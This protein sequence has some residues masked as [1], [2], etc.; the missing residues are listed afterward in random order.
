MIWKD[1]GG[2]ILWLNAWH[3]IIYNLGLKKHTP[4]RFG[5]WHL[6]S[7]YLIDHQSVVRDG[8]YVISWPNVV[9]QLISAIIQQHVVNTVIWKLIATIILTMD[10]VSAA[11]PYAWPH[12]G[13][14]Q[15]SNT[16]LIIVDVQVDHPFPPSPGP[17][18]HSSPV[19]A[20]WSPQYYSTQSASRAEK[21]TCT[22]LRQWSYF[23]AQNMSIHYS[24]TDSGWLY[25]NMASNEQ[26]N[27]CL[28]TRNSLCHS[29][30]SAQWGATCTLWAMTWRPCGL[31]LITLGTPVCQ[32]KLLSALHTW[33]SNHLV[34][35]W[36]IT[37]LPSLQWIN[38]TV[39]RNP[40][41]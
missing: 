24:H 28:L 6:M 17:S 16:A 34:L 11:S 25:L 3:Y 4:F 38:H 27:R 14:L 26:P 5:I 33:C 29:V 7:F 13:K 31:R 23:C 12:D 20:H 30:I 1:G 35:K 41:R 39:H 32:L 2:F 37:S 10:H 15:P 9:V 19:T 36:T 21:R 18:P 40:I 22:H 8:I